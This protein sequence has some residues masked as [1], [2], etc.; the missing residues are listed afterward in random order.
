MALQNPRGVITVDVPS[1]F[2]PVVEADAASIIITGIAPV[3]SLPNFSWN[4]SGYASVVNVA[5]VCNDAVDFATQLGICN[6]KKADGTWVYAACA[7]SDCAFIENNASLV[8]VINVNDP[9][10][11]SQ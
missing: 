9:W 10:V 7:L 5:T 3:G 4:V 6:A 1:S 8:V 11:H 2:T